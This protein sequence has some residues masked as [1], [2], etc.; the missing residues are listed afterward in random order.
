MGCKAGRDDKELKGCSDNNAQALHEVSVGNFKIGKYEVTQG[1]WRAVMK[2]T[3][4]ENYFCFGGSCGA[5]NGPLNDANCGPVAC[6]RQRPVEWISWYLSLAFCNRLSAMLG[7]TPVYGG[8]TLADIADNG[9][10]SVCNLGANVTVDAGANGYRLPTSKEW[11]YAARG[12]EAGSCENFT[13][14]GSDDL[15]EVGW[16]A[17]NPSPAFANST[18]N[19]VGQ[20]KP[21]GLG[22]HDMTGNVWEW[23]WERENSGSARVF[24]GGSWYHNTANG[25]SRVAAR[26][27]Y[28]PSVFDN[29]VGFRVVLP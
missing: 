1:V 16:N 12:C 19:P 21:N 18:T 17:T 15:Q 28:V 20:L 3:R 25:W 2:G 10:C 5:V 22:I 26:N 4:F 7:K 6:S 23:C 14:S 24:R 27:K 29:S 8:F 9:D 11:E 13:Y